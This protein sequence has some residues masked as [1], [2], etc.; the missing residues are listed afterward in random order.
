MTG[1]RW[2]SR[3]LNLRC[4]TA[5]ELISQQLDGPLGLVDRAQEVGEH[6]LVHRVQ[7][8]RPVQRELAPAVLRLDQD[9]V[10]HGSA[11]SGL[12]GGVSPAGS[13]TCATLSTMDTR[14]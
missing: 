1:P 6:R 13:C 10:G 3:I 5:T 11:Q 4:N 2:P 12:S 8:V 9:I 7:L 14:L